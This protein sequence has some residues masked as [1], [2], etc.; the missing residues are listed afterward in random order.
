[1]ASVVG[2]AP[3]EWRRHFPVERDAGRAIQEK[4][5]E[6]L[7]RLQARLDAWYER[8]VADKQSLIKRARHLLTQEDSREAIDAVKRL[9]VLWKDTGPAPGAQSQSLWNEFREV[10][11]AVYQKRQQAYAEYTGGLE[12][13]RVKAAAIC[14]EVEG[15]AALSGT[16]LLEG[17]TKITEWRT[18]FDA[19]GEMPR[20]EAR[21]LQVRFERAID[22]C[23]AQVAQQHARNAE[24]SFTNLFEAARR[25]NAYEW[26]ILQGGERNDQEAP[27]LEE[28][29]QA[30]E[31]FIAS[32]QH[33]PKGGLKTTK[34]N[35]ARVESIADSMARTES[36]ANSLATVDYE[37][38][39]KALRILCVRVEI[40]S[41]TSTPP[42][43][44]A[45][46]R[47]YQVQRLMRGIGQG[48]SA[49]DAD[50]GAIA[51]EWIRIGAVEPAQHDRLKERFLS[52]WKPRP[53]PIPGRVVDS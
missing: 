22:R 29:K 23:K 40:R 6:S 45:L 47:E 26:A 17:A 18:A 5:D 2:E 4:F 49:D 9:Q 12:A 50:G 39:E 31:N 16:P 51:V 11:D 14:E 35:L 13:N 38:R 53:N 1:V 21:G 20:T 27:K 24:Q 36:T 8:N 25:I 10:C 33:W 43:D 44:E 48:S 46:R 7:G 41:E 32:V 3:R 30:A 19:L 42:E 28:I 52:S 15:V 34:E 37:A